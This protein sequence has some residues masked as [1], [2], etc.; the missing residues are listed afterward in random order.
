MEMALTATV[1]AGSRSSFTRGRAY[2]VPHNH[3][4]SARSDNF[5]FP[6]YRVER[7]GNGSHGHSSCLAYNI[8]LRSLHEQTIQA[9]ESPVFMQNP[10]IPMGFL[11]YMQNPLIPMGFLVFM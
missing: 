4:V 1:L 5:S 10:L 3:Q 2:T 6:P 11:V 9:S 8:T 7:N